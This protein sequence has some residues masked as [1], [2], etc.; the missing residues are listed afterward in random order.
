MKS[1]PLQIL[2]NEEAIFLKY[3]KSRFPMF[4]NSN[5]FFRDFQFAVHAF[6]KLKE[7]NLSYSEAERIT[8]DFASAL[9]TA[10]VLIP[11]SKMNW[12]LNYP[13]FTVPNLKQVS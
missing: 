13:E 4:H 3:F 8:R 11:L 6:F 1:E 12:R 7:K 10:G 9:E 2:K 5:V